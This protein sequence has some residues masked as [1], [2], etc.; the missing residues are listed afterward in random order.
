MPQ[1]PRAAVRKMNSQ[2]IEL[3]INDRASSPS[4]VLCLFLFGAVV[5]TEEGSS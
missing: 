5:D 2:H 1:I 3:L 4:Q